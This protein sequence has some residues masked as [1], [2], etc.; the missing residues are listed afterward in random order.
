MPQSK[1][2]RSRKGIKEQNSD[3]MV[4]MTPSIVLR[5]KT[6]GRESRDNRGKELTHLATF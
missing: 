2:V 5:V 3:N 4:M 1:Y 6:Q